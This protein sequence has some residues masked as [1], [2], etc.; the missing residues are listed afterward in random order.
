MFSVYNSNKECMISWAYM[1]ISFIALCIFT[2]IGYGGI[3]IALSIL[4]IVYIIYY[5]IVSVER[6]IVLK[7][8]I[9]R[10]SFLHK[11]KIYTY[12]QISKVEEYKFRD[13]ESYLTFYCGD[14]VIFNV[15]SD[16]VNFDKLKKRF[17]VTLSN[18]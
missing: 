18:Y 5:C 8:R 4:F 2:I 3:A 1:V 6:I 10:Y 13:L 9:I 7:D 15:H 14:E 17:Y 16:M 11:K 12:S